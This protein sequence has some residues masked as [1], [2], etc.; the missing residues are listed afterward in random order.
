[1]KLAVVLLL[2][3]LVGLA[4]GTIVESRQGADVAGKL[5]YY[6]WWFLALQTLLVVNVA[7]SLVS[8]FPW[9]NGR[10]GYA[11]THASLLIIMLGA[12]NTFLLKKEGMLF[13]WEGESG[14]VI[15]QQ[16]KHGHVTS[17]LDLPFVVQLDDFVLET[18]PGTSKPSG[19]ASFVRVTDKKDG[20]SFNAKSG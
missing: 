10:I 14:S 20:H 2:L 16:D 9:I 12:A 5:V 18:Y 8:L 15:V 19:F 13:L 4:A 6:S 11:I 17:Q 7:M 1:L 3:L